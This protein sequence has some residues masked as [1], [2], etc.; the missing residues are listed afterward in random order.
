MTSGSPPGARR[1]PTWR[2]VAVFLLLSAV[3]L[4]LL[5]YLS[6]RFATDAVKDEVETRLAENAA[7][8][9]EVVRA[10]LQGLTELVDSY[11]ERPSLAA[12][13]AGGN[14]PT[15]SERALIRR[16]L[17]D[18]RGAR[19]GI[20]TTF[21]AE[22][23]GRLTD[24]VPPTPSIV[25][26]NFSFRDWYKGV[27]RTRRV[28]VSEAYRTQAT[29]HPLVV[30]AATPVRGPGS[31]VVAILV[32]AYSVE[33]LQ[34]L[35]DLPSRLE[36]DA[37]LEITDQRGVLVAETGRVPARLVSRAS[38]PRVAA[39]L[40]GR[41]GISEL[42]TPDGHRLSSYVPVGELG[43]TVTASVPENTA[44]AAVGKLRSTVLTIAAT[45]GLV[46]LGGLALLL[47]TLRARGRAEEEAD[48]LARINRA[49]LDATPDG[50]LLVDPEG[51]T[52]V[53]N[54]TLDRLGET[55]GFR[56][57]M[58][59]LADDPEGEAIHD[60]ERPDGRAFRMFT[61]P[62]RDASSELLGRVFVFQERTAEREAERLKSEL[63]ATVSHELRTPL[64]SVLGFAELLRHRDVD[65]QTHREYV[66]TIHGEALRLTNLIND[67]LDLQRIEEGSFT[68]SLD[69]FEL[70]DLL[71]DQVRLFSA[72]SSHHE[73]ELEL[74]DEPLHLL[75]ER[76]RIAQVVANLVS[77]AIK[78]SP[79]G[80]TVRV[81]AERKGDQVKVSVL[82]SGVG[83]P[84]DQQHRLFTKFFRVDS[85]DTRRIGGTGLGLALCREI[86][87]AHGGRIGFDSVEGEGSTFWFT[88]P[89]AHRRNGDGGRR[90]LIV[91][92]DPV[93]ASLLAEYLSED[94]YALEVAPTAEQALARIEEDP[95]AL[96][97]LDMAL[98]GELDGWEVMARLKASPATA[99]IPVIVC[100]GHDGRDRAAMLG[101]ADFITKPFSE[102]RIR[103]AVQ[104]VLPEGRGTVL[105]A[106]DDPTVR[107]LVAETLG[108]DEVDV[109]EAADGE[110]TLAALAAE[111]PDA[112]VLDLTMP[113]LD[114][115]QVLERLQETPELRLLP[116][117]ILTARRLS[118]Q[119]RA[120]LKERT[121]SLLEKSQ[122][123][124][125][126]LRALV[127]RVLPGPAE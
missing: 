16:H 70:R 49:V 120:Q 64:S 12:T 102:Q 5:T 39:A 83:I 125:Q 118:P 80:G 67:F 62:V 73:L 107:R 47:R 54:A 17:R 119:E 38:D 19:P 97:C 60:L 48:R 29:G 66:D 108:R 40:Q 25:G 110:E 114:G 85:S 52:V 31:G 116:V 11:A 69:P 111:L 10:E 7:T 74:P 100:T 57:A 105:V 61:A 98:P 124:S 82:D 127:A 91:E 13:L 21:V 34:R 79:S 9:A 37:K 30:A 35:S 121:V 8:S 77:N 28:Y 24:I 81:R 65:A 1:L 90:I 89:G 123:S 88:L 101:A 2:V 41:S 56:A 95:P 109:R 84:A 93:A 32:A 104:K 53:K 63:M 44:F 126:E 3:P 42:D 43:W 113:K 59:A 36:G 15:P 75:G 50:I 96:I 18:L 68:L 33:H 72:Q 14:D 45:L 115:F 6:L 99:Q 76:E 51:R 26:K 92:D 78:Y 22:P 122:Y 23:N 103:E 46:L 86:V 58:E 106:D 87:E 55:E 112:L 27:T 94:G 20:Y 117:I 4:A 71:R